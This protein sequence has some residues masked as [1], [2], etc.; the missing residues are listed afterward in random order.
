MSRIDWNSVRTEDLCHGGSSPD[1]DT[2]LDVLS[3]A[4]GFCGCGT[5]RPLEL[6]YIAFRHCSLPF[7]ARPT[8]YDYTELE[9]ELAIKVLDAYGILEHG[10]SIFGSWLSDEGKELWEWIGKWPMPVVTE[11][12]ERDE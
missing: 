12:A 3:T 10:S 5:D 9:W 6:L 1:E 8:S 11:G 2:A 7:D 4:L